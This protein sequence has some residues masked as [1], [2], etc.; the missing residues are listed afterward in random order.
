MKKLLVCGNCCNYPTA[1][2]SSASARLSFT[3]YKT[4]GDTPWSTSAWNYVKNWQKI[5]VFV[6]LVI[7]NLQYFAHSV[8][9]VQKFLTF[10][11]FSSINLSPE[12]T[13]IFPCY[14]L[15]LASVIADLNMYMYIT[16]FQPE[17]IG[18]ALVHDNL[19]RSLNCDLFL[20]S[21]TAISMSF[22]LGNFVTLRCYFMFAFL[23][24]MRAEWITVPRRFPFKYSNSCTNICCF[25]IFEYY[26]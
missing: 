26:K 25:Q 5:S 11:V 2:L 23:F 12:V 16:V 13:N 19:I 15:N 7:Q 17:N 8:I 9:I 20:Q 3:L 6:T 14:K 1:S 18:N 24:C 10:T 22:A 4:H 21:A